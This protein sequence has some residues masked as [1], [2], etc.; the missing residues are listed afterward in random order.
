MLPFLHAKEIAHDH[1]HGVGYSKDELL[2]YKAVWFCNDYIV[3]CVIHQSTPLYICYHLK[4]TSCLVL[5]QH[6]SVGGAG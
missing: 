2:S 6:S 5:L 1:M 3:F 4:Y